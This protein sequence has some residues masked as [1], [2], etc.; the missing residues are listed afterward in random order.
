MNYTQYTFYII[1][2][3]IYSHF[4]YKSFRIFLCD[5]NK[6]AILFYRSTVE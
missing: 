3:I 1:E 4:Y 5:N 2:Y 6:L